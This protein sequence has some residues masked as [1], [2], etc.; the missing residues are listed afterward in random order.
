[1]SPRLPDDYKSGRPSW[2]MRNPSAALTMA[3]GAM[4]FAQWAAAHWI[5]D[6]GRPQLDKIHKSIS[7]LSERDRRLSTY[8]LEYG[9]H[10]D[11]VLNVI[12]K[13]AGIKVPKWPAELD[14]ASV[15]VI[16]IQ[17]GK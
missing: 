15:H 1:M 12:G 6:R 10:M 4:V 14:R 2:V 9:R 11:N 16:R 5:Q 3:T 13:S 7:E 17:E 8:Q